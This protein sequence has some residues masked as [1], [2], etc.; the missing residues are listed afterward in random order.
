MMTL[1]R[2]RFLAATTLAAC[3][4]K[5]VG[6]HAASD[7]PRPPA[8]EHGPPDLGDVPLAMKGPLPRRP[9]GKTGVELALLG[10]GGYHLGTLPTVDDA[11]RLVHEALDHGIEFF[12]CAW[13]YHGGKSEDWLGQA[14]VDRRDKAFVMTKVCTHGRGADTAMK[15]LE[16]SL[17]RLR[18]D[19]LDLWQVHEVIYQN[20]PELYAQ[21]GSVTEAM[22][23]AKQQGK[24]RFVGFTGHKSPDMHLDMLAHGF[25]WDAVQ[26]PLNAFDGTGF[27]SFEQ[28]V[29][30][31]LRNRGI[32]PIG[33]KAMSGEGEAIKRGALTPAEAL[34]YTMSLP[35]SILISGID[36]LA[37]LHQNLNLAGGFEPFAERELARI[38][39]KAAIYAGDGRFELFKT[40]AKYDGDV[41]RQ[42]HGFPNHDQLGG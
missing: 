40:T 24:V 11:K 7:P 33:M 25:P 22:E 14:L 30:P 42:Q 17:R 5:S 6:P 20:E 36:S 18:T 27:R 26:M 19:H 37:V 12:D 8:S 2:R 38:R 23:R 35:I 29:L 9:L 34:G 4:P 3:A 13:E 31:E 1:S 21:R 15:M 41:G 39:A 32:A 10:L 16:D 28:R